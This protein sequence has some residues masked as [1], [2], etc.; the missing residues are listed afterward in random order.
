MMVHSLLWNHSKHWYIYC[1]QH[2]MKGFNRV[3]WGLQTENEWRK[4]FLQSLCWLNYLSNYKQSSL[5][6][7]VLIPKCF[8][9]N[10]SL[11][12]LILYAICTVSV[13][14]RGSWTSS[15][16]ASHASLHIHNLTAQICLIKYKI[17]HINKL[18][19][20]W[21]KGVFFFCFSNHW[22][23]R[24]VQCLYE[25]HEGASAHLLPAQTARRAAPL[26]WS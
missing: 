6:L 15:M 13:T 5:L 25:G 4:I 19:T 2:H 24:I 12:R 10:L 21:R 16:K 9:T 20:L 1:C 11:F 22:E 17:W 23:K 3:K 7:Y 14:I 18:W 8:L 26:P